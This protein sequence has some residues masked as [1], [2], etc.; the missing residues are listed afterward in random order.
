LVLDRDARQSERL[1]NLCA[2]LHFAARVGGDARSRT[3][4]WSG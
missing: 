4:A 3:R 2:Q 1:R